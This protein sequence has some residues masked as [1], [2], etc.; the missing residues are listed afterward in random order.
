MTEQSDVLIIGGGVIGLTAAYF[1]ARERVKVEIVDQSDFGKEA[2]WA[3]AGIIPPGDPTKARD[4]FDQ[5]RA[6][7]SVLYPK[8]SAELR[9]YTGIDNGYRRSG[10]LVFHDDKE[11][12]FEKE[13]RS[14][15]VRFE[16]VNGSGLRRLVPALA[17][18]RIIA[19]FLPELAQVRNPWHLKAL[20]CY[21]QGRGVHLLP[22]CPVLGFERQGS[23]VIG[24][25][26]SA[27]LLRAERYLLTAGAWAGGLLEPLGCRLGIRPMRGQIALLNTGVPIF[28]HVLL[29]GKRYLVPRSDGRVLVGSTEEDVGFDQG[30]TA[31][32]IQGLMAFAISLVPSLAGAQPERSWA[33]LRPGSPDG[34]PFIGPVPGIENLFVAAGHFRAGIQLSPATGL[35]LKELFLGQ[36]LTVSLDGFRLDRILGTP[37]RS[38]SLAAK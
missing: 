10:G 16:E 23:R 14:E 8:L 30:T 20:I 2:S 32:A 17:S 6:H 22:N 33:G 38:A 4:P 27:G 31:E 18:D 15:G 5:L 3:G 25:R 12:Y 37:S 34:M 28:H 35:I 26:T 1:L 29:Q 21:C 13:W 9:E 11:S 7:S 19:F 24:V 36:P